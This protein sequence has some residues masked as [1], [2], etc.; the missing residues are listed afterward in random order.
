M[1]V[2][3]ALLAAVVV[4]VAY[5]VVVYTAYIVL[6][7]VGA[8]ENR[9]RRDESAAEDYDTIAA[10]RFTIPVSVI[11]PAYDEETAIL[12]SVQSLLA[13]DYPEF[14]V[15]VVNDGSSDRTLEVL[16]EEYALEPYELFTRSLFPSAEVHGVYRSAVEPRL[17]VVDKENGGK[18]DGLNAGLN[19]A[20]SRYVCCVDA[21]TIFEPDALLKAMRLV[22]EDPARVIGVASFLTVSENALETMSEPVGSRRIGWKPLIA[23]QQL[24]FM[25]AFFNN[26]LAWSRLDFMLCAPG[27]FQVWRKDVLEE[28]GGYESRFS[29][30][31]IELTYR[32]HERMRREQRDYKIICLPDNVATTEGPDTVRKLVSQRERWQRV[33][34]ETVVHYRRLLFNPR[35]GAVGLVGA[36]FY[37]LSEVLAPFFEVLALVTIPVAAF[38][39]V[40]DWSVFLLVVGTLGLPQ[41][42]ADGSRDPGERRAVP[43]LPA[44][45]P[46]VAEP[47][48]PAR[49]RRVPT[50]DGLGAPQGNLAVPARRQGVAQVRA[51]PAGSG[52]A[53]T[54]E[55]RGRRPRAN[56]A[57]PCASPS[58]RCRRRR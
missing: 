23:F 40:L 32:V 18:A 41:R 47:A 36:P 3:Q 14:E 51:E 13:F 33:I 53:V 35:Y 2:E 28:V 19:V 10:S 38:L 54:G 56:R 50:G 57:S 15:I 34:I 20:R 48:R 17:L 11:A 49:P 43:H 37:L 29:C 31:D 27:A 25:R 9:L 4:S 45:R 52:V 21:D 42:G 8:F 5:L 39:G 7:V 26:R 12:D 44:A 55:R 16:Q 30:E 22:V 58:R 46:R 1:T 24:D 6:V